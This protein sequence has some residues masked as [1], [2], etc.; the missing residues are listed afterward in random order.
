MEAI[1]ISLLIV[2]ILAVPI[3]LL[4]WFKATISSLIREVIQKV[5][6]L[7]IKIDKLDQSK[8]TKANLEEE[9]VSINESLFTLMETLPKEDERSMIEEI[10][11]KENEV[12]DELC[13]NL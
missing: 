8:E 5:N 1:I 11:E 13:E 7:H 4:V 6:Y 9:N 10:C 3:I 2:A 12:A